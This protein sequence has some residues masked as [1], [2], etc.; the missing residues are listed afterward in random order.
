MMASFVSAELIERLRTQQ[1]GLRGAL[2]T[3]EHHATASNDP[4]LLA[5]CRALAR[6]YRSHEGLVTALLEAVEPDRPGTPSA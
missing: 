6:A 4:R 1:R 3:L 2:Q 5:E